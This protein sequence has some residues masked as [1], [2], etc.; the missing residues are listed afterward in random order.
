MIIVTSLKD[1]LDVCETTQPSHLISV[2]DPGFEPPTP[3]GILNHLCLG[4][5]DIIKISQNNLIHRNENL[6]EKNTFTNQIL[7]NNEHIG[8]IVNFV[9]SWD[10]SKPIVIHCWS[11]VSRSMAV[12]TFIICKINPSNI[13]Q[14]IKYIRS[15]APHANPNK[16]MLSLFEKELGIDGKIIESYKKYPYT[17]KYDCS[18]NFAPITIFN[19]NEISLT[20]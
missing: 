16:L 1:H 2:I 6:L 7:P 13:D 20:S 18:T 5:D 15:L 17:K 3:K 10:M 4:F 9:E 19:I 14:N 12:A 11:G 8:K